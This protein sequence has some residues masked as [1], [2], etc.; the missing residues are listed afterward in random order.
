MLLIA[1]LSI[2]SPHKATHFN[3]TNFSPQWDE[4][5]KKY[6]GREG[7]NKCYLESS[8]HVSSLLSFKIWKLDL[9]SLTLSNYLNK[10]KIL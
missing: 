3:D 8:I 2:F 1:A 10:K 4:K 7:E 9:L 5:E 6:L